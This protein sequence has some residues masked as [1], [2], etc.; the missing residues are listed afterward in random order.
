MEISEYN[1]ITPENAANPRYDPFDPQRLYRHMTY[2]QQMSR[3]R[4]YFADAD[5]IILTAEAGAYVYWLSVSKRSDTETNSAILAYIAQMQPVLFGRPETVLRNTKYSHDRLTQFY[6]AVVRD[7][8]DIERSLHEAQ[9]LCAART[10]NGEYLEV[11]RSYLSVLQQRSADPVAD[12]EQNEALIALIRSER[13]LLCAPNGAVK[14][15][16][17]QLDRCCT[18]ICRAFEA[19]LNG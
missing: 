14:K 10:A 12:Y 2:L 8:R 6:S 3:A 7:V 16:Y 4:V 5:D 18:A 15:L 13:Y 1:R 11:M 19:A 9:N 17:R